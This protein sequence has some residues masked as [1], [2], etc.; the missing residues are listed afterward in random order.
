M[1]TYEEFKKVWEDGEGAAPANNAGS[2]AVA[3][4]TVDTG[5]PGPQPIGKL[6]LFRKKKK[7]TI[8]TMRG[9]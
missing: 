5:L 2:G 6:G 3:G 7:G 4:F 9:Q 1:R 8:E